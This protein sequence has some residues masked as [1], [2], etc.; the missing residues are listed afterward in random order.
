MIFVTKER[1]GL[2]F[3]FARFTMDGAE[4][5]GFIEIPV[6]HDTSDDVLNEQVLR[7]F[8]QTHKPTQITDEQLASIVF[9]EA[10]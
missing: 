5:T 2:T 9:I 7:D 10:E 1:D 3:L 8:Q 6:T 4:E